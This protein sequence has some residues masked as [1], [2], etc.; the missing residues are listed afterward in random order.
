MDK[1]LGPIVTLILGGLLLFGGGIAQKG[2]LPSFASVTSSS[3]E[4]SKLFLI[5][6]KQAPTVDQVIALRTVADFAK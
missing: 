2:G 4:G 3:V 5:Y 6:E 1:P